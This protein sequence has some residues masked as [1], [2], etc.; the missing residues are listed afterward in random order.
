M[1]PHPWTEPHRPAAHPDALVTINP[2]IDDVDTRF[3]AHSRRPLANFV[4]QLIAADQHLPQ[5]RVHRRA[6]PDEAI[7]AYKAP[8]SRRP[9]S[10]LGR[11]WL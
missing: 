3:E 7:A 4:A 5:T 11:R 8:A 9:G 2:E 10:G 1:S 6:E